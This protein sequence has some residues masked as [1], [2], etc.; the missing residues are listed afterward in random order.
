MGID[1]LMD[2][3]MAKAQ[4]LWVG[5]AFFSVATFLGTLAHVARLKA[6][7][8]IRWESLQ[9]HRVCQGSGYSPRYMGLTVGIS[10]L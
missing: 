10:C 1:W 2:T 8:S 7:K 6:F 5:L 9:D 3:R 4:M